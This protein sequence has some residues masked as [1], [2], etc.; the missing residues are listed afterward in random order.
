MSIHWINPLKFGVFI[1]LACG[2]SACSAPEEGEEALQFEQ[3]R[4]SVVAILPGDSPG[5]I[6]PPGQHVKKGN[7]FT[8]DNPPQIWTVVE[9]GGDRIVWQDQSGGRLTTH[10]NTMLPALAWHTGATKGRREIVNVSGALF[11]LKEGNTLSFD[12]EGQSDRPPSRWRASWRCAVEAAKKIKVKAGEADTFPVRCRR[13]NNDVLLF[14]F[15]PQI[16][17][18]VRYESYQQGY[19]SVRQ[20]TVYARNAPLPRPPEPKP[21][22][23]RSNQQQGKK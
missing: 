14:H 9:D 11:P 3:L 16:G 21:P 12:V 18:Y 7:Q 10:Y 4:G 22:V 19:S 23:A 2:A 6:D 15:S 8:F 20:L 5:T 13:N 1:V 17:H